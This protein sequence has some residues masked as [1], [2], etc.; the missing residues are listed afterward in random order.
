L[1]CVI[2]VNRAGDTKRKKNEKME[3]QGGGRHKGSLNKKVKEF[4]L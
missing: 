4:F 2:P 1:I 3:G